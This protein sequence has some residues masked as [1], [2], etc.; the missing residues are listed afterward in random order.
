MMKYKKTGILRKMRV[1][2][3][4]IAQYQFIIGDDV[5]PMNELLG[6]KISL[7]SQHKI[8]CIQCGRKT[9]KSF[10]QGFCFPCMQRLNECGNCVIHPERCKVEQLS[11]IH[12]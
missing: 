4:D 8:Y 9:S 12:I 1:Q 6:T 10:Q 5:V 2:L 11:L 3:E 7:Q